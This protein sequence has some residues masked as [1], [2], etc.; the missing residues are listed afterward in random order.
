VVRLANVYGP[1]S[2]IRSPEFGFVNFFVGLGLQ[3]RDLTV[4]G[5]GAQRR[6]LSY[7][8]D[9]VDAMLLAATSPAADGQVFFA[10]AD[11]QLTV[12]EIADA[13]ATHVGGRIR[14]V[15]WPKDRAAIEIGDA[16]ISNARIKTALGWQPRHDLAAGMTSTRAYFGDCLE[17]YL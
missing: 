5:D 16:V 1:R 14:N 12:R 4:F 10:A 13:I 6:N 2:N 7:V 11:Q 15:E 8:D 17:R 3:Q 9:V